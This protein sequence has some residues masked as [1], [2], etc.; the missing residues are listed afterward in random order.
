MNTDPLGASHRR[1]FVP[2]TRRLRAEGPALT[3]A[4]ARTAPHD[5]LVPNPRPD[6]SG[7]PCARPPHAGH[8]DFAD[9]D[10]MFWT[11][12]AHTGDAA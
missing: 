7:A 9:P 8:P 12:E 4:P 1:R 10:S 11:P 3:G 6:L 5:F 2:P